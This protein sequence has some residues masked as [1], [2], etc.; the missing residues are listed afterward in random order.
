MKLRP[1]QLA[2]HLQEPLKAVYLIFGEETLLVQEA[3]DA[4]RAAARRQGFSEREV[5]HGERGAD[6][7][8]LLASASNM[9]LFGDRKIIEVRFSGK[10]DAQ[11][12]A[13]LEQYAQ[14]PSPD[15]LLLMMLPKLDG[16]AQKSKWFTACENAGVSIAIISVDR[17]ALPD[18]LRGRLGQAGLQLSPEALTLLADK[19]EGNLLAASQE[20]E[21]LRLLYGAGAL[22]IEQVRDAVGDSSRYNL[23]DLADCILDGQSARAARMLLGL[24][25]EGESESSVLWTLSRD[26]RALT[27]ISEGVAQGQQAF[28]LMQQYGIWQK[29][30]PLVQKALRRHSLASLQGLLQDALTIDKAIKGQHPDNPWDALLRLALALSGQALFPRV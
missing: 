23:Y 22:T 4:L 12:A 7:N 21:K 15:N 10:P 16:T 9:S 25:A 26:V 8:E 29:R 5:M 3:A 14:N 17:A 27:G 19:V 2:R 30:Q 18:W 28:A 20:V 24:K 13:A 6:W 11:A 1:D